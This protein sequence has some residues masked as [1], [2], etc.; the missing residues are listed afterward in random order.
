MYTKC[1]GGDTALS[2]IFKLVKCSKLFYWIYSKQ[3]ALWMNRWSKHQMPWRW[4]CETTCKQYTEY[5]ES[6]IPCHRMYS[7]SEYRKAVAYMTVFHPTL[8]H[9]ALHRLCYQMYF[10]W[11]DTKYLFSCGI[12]LAK[13]FRTI[14]ISDKKCPKF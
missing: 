8:N 1:W 9:L 14:L 3:I 10:L 12:L 11:H 4:E 2:F 6:T 13:K 5:N 7:Q